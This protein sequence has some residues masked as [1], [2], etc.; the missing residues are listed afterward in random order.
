MIFGEV[1]GSGNIII[2]YKPFETGIYLPGVDVEAV[3][4]YE[5]SH[6]QK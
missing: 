2:S 3:N 1:D 4:V 5:L 6:W